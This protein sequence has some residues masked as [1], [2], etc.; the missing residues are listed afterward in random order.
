MQLGEL[1]P[2]QN[3]VLNVPRGRLQTSISNQQGREDK[4]EKGLR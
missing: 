3:Q 1:F 4:S 2:F